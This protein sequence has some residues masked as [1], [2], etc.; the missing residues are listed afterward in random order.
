MTSFVGLGA[1]VNWAISASRSDRNSVVAIVCLLPLSS[2]S[3]DRMTGSQPGGGCKGRQPPGS[4]GFARARRRS[5]SHAQ[6][7]TR[8]VLYAPRD[9]GQARGVVYPIIEGHDDR[10]EL[11]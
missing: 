6:K 3:R 7:G 10:P 11:W 5:L 1:S 8:G 2:A 4:L 9:G